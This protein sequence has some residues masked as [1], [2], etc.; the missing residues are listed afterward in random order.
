MTDTAICAY[1]RDVIH[2]EEEIFVIVSEGEEREAAETRYAHAECDPNQRRMT[3]AAAPAAHGGP[4]RY[5]KLSR[6]R[7]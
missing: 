6:R 5:A 4:A 3:A 1:C 7:G 2:L